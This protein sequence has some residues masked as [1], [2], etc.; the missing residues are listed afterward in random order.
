N[1]LAGTTIRLFADGTEIASKANAAG[2]RD[3]IKLTSSLM[4]GT[5]LT[6]TQ[7]DSLGSHSEPTPEP[8]IV[9]AIPTPLPQAYFGGPVFGCVRLMWINGLVPGASFEVHQPSVGAAP[10][11][12]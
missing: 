11:A 10:S 4:P 7:E 12:G 2:G 9:D 6:T 1:Q 8:L 5:R 3:E